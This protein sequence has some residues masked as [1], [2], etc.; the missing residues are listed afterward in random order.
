VP[1]GEG[2]NGDCV[3]K[4]VSSGEYKNGSHLRGKKGGYVATIM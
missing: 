2:G 4:Q 1:N 3:R